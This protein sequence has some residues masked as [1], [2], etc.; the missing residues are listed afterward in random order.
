MKNNNITQKY[1]KYGHIR[2]S[3]RLD[4]F[5]AQD[6]DLPG[7]QHIISDGD[8]DRRRRTYCDGI[9][10]RTTMRLDFDHPLLPPTRVCEYASNFVYYNITA[11]AAALTGRSERNARALKL[12]RAV[13]AWPYYTPLLGKVRRRRVPASRR[14]YIHRNTQ[15]PQPH[16]PHISRWRKEPF[17]ETR[18]HIRVRIASEAPRRR[19]RRSRQRRCLRAW[20]PTRRKF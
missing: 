1:Q 9:C 10:K 7:S 18:S 5:A 19:N 6:S 4:R 17:G 16:Q 15:H 3:A 13:S 2:N 20:A 8:D 12:C 14:T 11:A